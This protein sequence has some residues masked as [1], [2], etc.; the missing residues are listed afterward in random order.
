[1]RGT[2]RCLLHRRQAC[3]ASC[4]ALPIAPAPCRLWRCRARSGYSHRRTVLAGRVTLC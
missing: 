3:A 2:P 1:V 4:R